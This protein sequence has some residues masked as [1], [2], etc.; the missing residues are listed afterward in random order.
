M[1]IRVQVNPFLSGRWQ[2][3]ALCNESPHGIVGLIHTHTHTHTERE[4]ERERERNMRASVTSRFYVHGD[5]SAGLPWIV[6]CVCQR[7]NS[8]PYKA[9]PSDHGGGAPTE[10]GLPG[11]EPG[12]KHRPRP[13][14]RRPSASFASGCDRESAHS[15][16][17]SDRPNKG[18]SRSSS[19]EGL[20]AVFSLLPRRPSLSLFLSLSVSYLRSEP[21]EGGWAV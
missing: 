3:A 14:R 21:G 18:P 17:G 19:P 7:D 16:S 10:I 1:R 20:T 5:G 6:E 2:C 11:T 13:G 12:S 8:L 15:K 4:R 9:A